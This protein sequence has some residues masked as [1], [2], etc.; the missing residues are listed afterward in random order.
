L[1]EKLI[2]DATPQ[3]VVIEF[4][5]ATALEGR[6]KTSLWSS[7]SIFFCILKRQK[8]MIKRVAAQTLAGIRT[9]T[10]K[11]KLVIHRMLENVFGKEMVGRKERQDSLVR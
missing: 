4:S 2:R 8:R 11:R 10:G 7:S 9:S 1:E 6:R 3:D 5:P